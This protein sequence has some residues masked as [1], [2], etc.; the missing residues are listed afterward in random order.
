MLGD[1]A[2]RR[3]LSAHQWRAREVAPIQPAV[4]HRTDEGATT[5]PLSRRS[6]ILAR[7]GRYIRPTAEAG[8]RRMHASAEGDSRRGAASVSATG[9]GFVGGSGGASDPG[10]AAGLP[11]DAGHRDCGTDCLAVFDP[12]VERAGGR[13]AGCPPWGGWIATNA[14]GMKHNRHGNIEDIVENVTLVTTPGGD[15][16]GLR[17][18]NI[19]HWRR[20]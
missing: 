1:R 16:R 9:A 10:V 7:Q 18:G 14:S 3:A 6:P 13:A 11:D 12:H 19:N 17:R 2:S 5:Q 20:Q 15:C 8:R 4:L